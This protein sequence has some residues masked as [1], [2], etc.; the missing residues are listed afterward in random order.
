MTL[1]E[2]IPRMPTV[3]QLIRQDHL[4]LAAYRDGRLRLPY[5]KTGPLWESIVRL[6]FAGEIGEY[7][8]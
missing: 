4:V 5:P 6:A 1:D 8:T 7:R 2:L 3:E